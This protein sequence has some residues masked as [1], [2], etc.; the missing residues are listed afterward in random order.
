MSLA[1]KMNKVK[2]SDIPPEDRPRLNTKNWA[3][4]GAP[5]RS[6]TSKVGEAIPRV[7]P[8]SKGGI[9]NK[10]GKIPPSAVPHIPLST[11]IT[12]NRVEILSKSDIRSMVHKQ[13]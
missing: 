7:G 10:V 6:P 2:I 4:M 3:I 1:R 8:K 9:A 13:H 11:F 5:N 12:P